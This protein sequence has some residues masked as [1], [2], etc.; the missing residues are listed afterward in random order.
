MQMRQRGFYVASLL[1]ALLA[2]GL[3]CGALASY[4]QNVQAR[5]RA[6]TVAGEQGN[7]MHGGADRF[8]ARGSALALLG[9]LPALAS[10]I[11]LYVSFRRRERAWLWLFPIAL[12]LLYAGLMFIQV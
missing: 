8:T 11:C 1:L 4:S 9:F 3:H 2:V 5:A 7:A 6:A 10:S 12:L